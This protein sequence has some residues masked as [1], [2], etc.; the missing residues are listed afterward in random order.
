MSELSD[1]STLEDIQVLVDTFYGAIREDALLGPIF[2]ERIGDRWPQH[3]QK[4]YSFWQTVL[5][6]QHT[7]NGRPFP[8]HARL[9][10]VQLHFDTWLGLWF[11]TVDDHFA[12]PV[13]DDAKFRG[14]RMALLF[15]SKIEY[16]RNSGGVSFV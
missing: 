6:D 9:P 1:I 8:P 4:M 14:D 3:L 7:Y 16:F 10:V 5:L 12:G 13:A 15:L 2:N 11:K